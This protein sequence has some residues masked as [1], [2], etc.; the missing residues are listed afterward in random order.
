MQ[1][2]F[3][4]KD[5]NTRNNINCEENIIKLIEKFRKDGNEVIFI[6]HISKEE[7]LSFKNISA[8][9]LDNI[10]PRSNEKCIIKNV[11]SAFIG[12]DLEKYLRIKK[13]KKYQN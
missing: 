2:G 1:K 3:L 11:N 7:N 6:K 12:A 8:E 5:I 10:T 13:W 4:I 9:F